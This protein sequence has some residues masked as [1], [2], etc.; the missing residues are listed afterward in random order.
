VAVIQI[1][2]TGI[3]DMPINV[4]APPF[5]DIK[6]RRATGLAINQEAIVASIDNGVGAPAHNFLISSLPEANVRP[7]AEYQL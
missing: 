4:T 3:N 5:D 1:A 6:V 7:S 2:G